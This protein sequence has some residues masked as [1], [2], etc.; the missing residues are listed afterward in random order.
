M[1]KFIFILLLFIS[2]N[3]SSTEP[4]ET[5]KGKVVSV[6]DGD[7]M[8]ILTDSEERIK[9]RLYGI[10][11]PEKGQDFSNK[12]RTYLNDLC[13]GKTVKVEKKDIDQYDR[14]LGIVYLDELNLNQ[15]MVKEG[16]A[17]YYNHYVED[18]V[19]EGLE[20]TARQQKLNIWSLKNPT[21]PYEY[22]KKQRTERSKREQRN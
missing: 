5:I 16:L 11:A 18:P 4:T 22:R 1:R 7:T 21:P 17:W 9:V 6:A 14:T 8:T 13:Y 12:A 3:P 10:D 2:C 19:L 20:K 15:E